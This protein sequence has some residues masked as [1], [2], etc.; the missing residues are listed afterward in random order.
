MRLA[1]QRVAA[2]GD[3]IPRMTFT[4]HGAPQLVTDMNGLAG[5]TERM[6]IKVAADGSSVFNTKEFKPDGGGFNLH[7]SGKTGA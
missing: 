6:K 5:K 2:K 3:G 4:P 1:A 7:S